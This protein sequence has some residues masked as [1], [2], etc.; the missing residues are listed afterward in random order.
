MSKHIWNSFLLS[1]ALTQSF[2]QLPRFMQVRVSGAVGKQLEESKQINRSLAALGNV[3]SALTDTKGRS[4]V[5]Y[6]DSKLTRI[7]EDRCA[8]RVWKHMCVCGCCVREYASAKTTRGEQ[9]N[10][11]LA[12]SARQR[13]LRAH[14]HEGVLVCAVSG[15]KADENPR[16]QVHM[17]MRLS[18]C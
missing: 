2:C 5:P 18:V 11:L 8:W 13:H 17:G 3:I 6:R 10:Q 14:R 16:R 12:G 4:H 1:W 7:L 15:L 9:A